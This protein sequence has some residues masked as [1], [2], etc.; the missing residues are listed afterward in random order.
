MRL[1]VFLVSFKES[2]Y[3]VEFNCER[4]QNWNKLS[5][6]IDINRWKRQWQEQQPKS[7]MDCHVL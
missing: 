7:L 5:Y 3:V 2:V 4:K 1:I 6:K